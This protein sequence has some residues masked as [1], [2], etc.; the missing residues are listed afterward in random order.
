MSQ[1][2]FAPYWKGGLRP[3]TTHENFSPV[4]DTVNENAFSFF[5]TIQSFAEQSMFEL[6]IQFPPEDTCA[7][8]RQANEHVAQ[9]PA[10]R[11]PA[12]AAAQTHPAKSSNNDEKYRSSYVPTLKKHS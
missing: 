3:S 5:R 8:Q 11:E 1:P 2:G 12:T 7:I 9:R 4:I 6:Q 10:Q